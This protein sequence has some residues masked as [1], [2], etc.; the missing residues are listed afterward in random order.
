MMRHPKRSSFGIFTIRSLFNS[1]FSYSTVREATTHNNKITVL[2]RA[3]QLG[4]LLYIFGWD[5]VYKKSYQLVDKGIST[6]TTKVKGVGY[7]DKM[8]IFDKIGKLDEKE[9]NL[10]VYDTSMFVIPPNEYNSIFV[11]TNYIE[12]T[13]SPGKCDE[14]DT[15]RQAICNTDNDCK[16]DESLLN[17]WNGVPTGKCIQST[18]NAKKKV[19]EIYA[20]CPVE[21][22]DLI[23][24]NSIKNIKH[25][26]IFIRNDINFLSFDERRSNLPNNVTSHFIQTCAS[27]PNR[28]PYCPVFSI[29]QILIE[30]EPDSHERTIM[31]EKGG[32]IVIRIKWDCD[33]DLFAKECL[34]SYSFTRYDYKS[35]FS[36]TVSGFNFRFSQH[37][38]KDSVEYRKLVKAYGLR[39]MIQVDSRAGKFNFI[40]LLVSLGSGIGLLAIPMVIAD[41]ILLNF[42]ERKEFYRDL[43]MY[44][45][46]A[47]STSDDGHFDMITRV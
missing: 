14:D 24:S 47:P 2:Y 41:C 8:N 18:V 11:M 23:F 5:L 15:K 28:S 20:W 21:R 34:P 42:T 6:V 31:L 38:Y 1:Y 44:D 33:F 7:V 35:S 4:I 9:I 39:F 43:K 22:D 27:S 29:E 10:K 19:C 26:T 13:Q 3:L 36:S 30:A 12:S 25:H 46:V 45:I 32:I 16:I 37:F 17:L 40:P